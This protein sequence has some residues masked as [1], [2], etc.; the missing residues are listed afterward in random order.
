MKL[1]SICLGFLAV[2]TGLCFISIQSNLP[3]DSWVMGMAM[4]YLLSLGGI[5][6]LLY[7]V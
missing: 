2:V 6:F 1:V 3:C 4:T 7:T 5:S